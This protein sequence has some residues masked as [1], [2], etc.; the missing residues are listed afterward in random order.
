MKL[1]K[2]LIIIG[3]GIINIL[4]ASLH[5]IQFIQSILLVRASTFGPKI[6]HDVGLIDRILHSPYFA[7]LWGI[8]GLFTLWIGI[9][10][11]IHHRK[12]SH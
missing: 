4:H 11:F 8:V 12:C 7:I 10:D 5:I 2:S 9:K 3:L 1:R 6:K